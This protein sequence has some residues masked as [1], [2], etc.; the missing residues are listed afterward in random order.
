MTP[1]ACTYTILLLDILSSDIVSGINVCYTSEIFMKRARRLFLSL[2]PYLTVFL[3]SLHLPFDADLGWH[4][5]YGEYFFQHGRLLRDNI[6]STDMAWFHWPNTSW[7][8]DLLNYLI[9]QNF[10]FFGLTIAGALVITITFFFISRAFELSYWEKA[11]IFPLLLYVEYPLNFVSFRGSLLSMMLLSVLIYLC[12]AYERRS[13]KR[14]YF[15]ILL[16]ILWANLHGQFILGIGIFALWITGY[17]FKLFICDK[18]TPKIIFREHKIL[19]FTLFTSICATFIHP[20]GIGIYGDAF[21]HFNNPL[22]KSIAEY[23]P[24]AQLSSLW[25]DQV[26]VGVA[27]VIGTIFIFFGGKI[28][29]SIPFAG[30]FWALYLLTF[31]VR[32]YGWSAYYF[33]VPFLK[34]VANF[35]KPD[36]K[37]HQTFGAT[38]I[39]LITCIIVIS[40][41][42]PLSQYMTM[43]WDRYCKGFQHCSPKAVEYVKEHNLDKKGD[44]MTFYDWGGYII[45]NYP[46]IKPSI[47]GRMHLWSDEKGYSAFN[48]YYSLE[49]NITDID[50]SYYDAVLMSPKK[51]VYSR[52]NTLVAKGKW[53]KVYEDKEA[54]VFVRKKAKS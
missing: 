31:W 51:P 41:K 38:G 32:R 11:F 42:L 25:W 9:F 39:F 18:F 30:V 44:L 16:F 53:K 27:V 12:M 20:Y 43:S 17:F 15:M 26:I 22:L 48:M 24:F 14:I 28:A 33:A 1:A 3:A 7:G 52:L 29:D 21:V 40:T 4:L 23:L 47:D 49:Q 36:T 19:L 34:P 13:S 50:K 6:F 46:D 45:W 8:I 5:R 35:F 54:G 2:L 37:K 10:G